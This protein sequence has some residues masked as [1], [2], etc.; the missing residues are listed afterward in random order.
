MKGRYFKNLTY[1]SIGTFFKFFLAF[2]SAAI[3]IRVIGTKGY[4]IIGI[5]FSF[6]NI[7]S[8]L[9]YTCFFGLVK[10]NSKKEQDSKLYWDVFNTLHN[11][12]IL[13]GAFIFFILL[14]IT[15]F[16]S[17]Y[18]YADKGLMIFY[19]LGISILVLDRIVQFLRQFIRSNRE[20]A[21]IQ[22][23]YMSG[24][25]LEFTL[26]LFFLLILDLGV[27]SI[28]LGTLISK[29]F[30]VLMLYIITLRKGTKFYLF[31]SL[32][33]FIKIFK[34]YAFKESISKL[35]KELL[36]WG[37]LLIATVYLGTFYLGL[38]TF[39]CIIGN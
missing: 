1:M 25:F 12:I 22:K 13:S 4:A 36:F 32:R 26:T 21:D 39:F 8:R 34:E 29:F 15:Y 35:L 24:L 38:L 23:A 5:V 16:L 11:S 17:K 30:E 37:G 10:Y 14:P 9:D 3:L 2:I 6:Y 18:V 28:F 31:F 27:M 7:V 20:E 19:F 33:L